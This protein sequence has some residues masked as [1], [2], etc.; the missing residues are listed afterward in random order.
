M[1][2]LKEIGTGA[3]PGCT[4]LVGGRLGTGSGA[5]FPTAYPATREVLAE[6]PAAA[7]GEVDA[8]LDAAREAFDRGP[9]PRLPGEERA[10]VLGAMADALARRLDRARELVVLDNGKSV[11]DAQGDPLACVAALRS[12]AGAATRLYAEQPMPPGDVLRLTWREPVGVVAGITPFN[13]PLMFAG[14]KAAPALAAGNTVVL[15]PSPRAPLAPALLAEAAV[16]AGLPPGALNLVQGGTATGEALI[17]DDRVDMV[18]LTGGTAAGSA[19]LVAG[20]PTIKRSLLELGG[21]SANIVFADADLDRAVPSAL[22]A[23]FRNAGQRCLSGTRLL[24]QRAV[25][26]E[27]LERLARGAERLRVGDPFDPSTQVGALVDGG[28]LDAVAGFVERAAAAGA[29]V[30]AGG[31]AVADLPGWFYRPTVLA[32]EDNAHV[33]AQEECFGPVLTVLAFDDEE[34]A[35]AI[36]NDSRYGLAGGVWTGDLSRGLRVA[37]GVR[38]G[39]LWVNT[40]SLVSGDVP[41]GGFKQSGLGREAGASGALAYTEEKTVIADLAGALPPIAFP[42]L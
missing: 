24:V 9:W 21:K 20:A 29:E 28:A 33:A 23:V 11:A 27:V 36:A 35:I 19:V 41:F 4:Q 3:V 22:G 15:K 26:D 1:R 31:R 17:A 7:D 8:A 25:H 34:E 2:T 16:E 5:R 13:A 12:A 39:V 6:V 40:Y 32:V 10:R 14:L 42:E 37:R 30:L 18:T 38:T